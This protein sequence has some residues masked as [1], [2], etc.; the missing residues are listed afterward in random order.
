[1]NRADGAFAHQR[2]AIVGGG[3]L[4]GGGCHVVISLVLDPFG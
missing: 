4:C 3:D 2:R 1:V